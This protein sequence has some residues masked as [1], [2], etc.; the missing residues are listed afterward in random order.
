MLKIAICDDDVNFSGKLENMLLEIKRTEHIE[1]ELEVYFDGEELVEDVCKKGK[2]YDLIFLDIEMAKMDGIVAAKEI[3]KSDDLTELIYVTSHE[4]YSV[5]AYNV[6]P[7]QFIVKPICYDTVHKHFMSAYDK[8]T[9]GPDYFICEFK[10]HAHILRMSEIMYFKSNRRV[11]QAYVVDGKTYPFYGKMDDLEER[12]MREKVDFW[13]IHQS[14]LV[15]VRYIDDIS[16][17][18]IVLKNGKPLSISEK[19]RKSVGE[20]YCNYIK[21]NIIE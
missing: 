13:R 6:H 5:E 14:Y 10:T 17:D 7:F 15:N 21:G 20:K 8:L 19:R 3:R 12:L 4:S 9:S 2:R 16:Y 18:K 1:L 11:L